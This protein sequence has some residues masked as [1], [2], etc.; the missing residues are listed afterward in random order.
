VP[1]GGRAFDALA[2]LAA[3][4]GATVGKETLLDA[5]WPGLTVEENNLQVQIS[6]LRKVLGEGWIVTVPGRGYR[7][8]PPPSHVESTTA[9]TLALPDKPSIA[10]LPFQNI[11]GDPEQEYFADGMVEEIIT[12]LSRVRWFFVIARNSSFAYKGKSPDVRQVGRELGVRYVL[13]GSVRKAGNRVRITGQLVDAITGAHVWADRFDG[14]LE[15]IFDLQDRVTSS[16]VSAIEPKIRD[17]EIVRAQRKPTES[18]QAYDLV[19]RAIPH[20]A[21]RSRDGHREATR[22]LEHAIKIDPNYALALSF[23][24]WCHNLPWAQGWLETRPSHHEIMRLTH[25]ALRYGADDPAVLANAG[26]LISQAGGDLDGGLALME[27]SLA[28]NPNS[29]SASATAGGMYAY[30]GNIDKALAYA[31]RATRLDPVEKFSFGPNF[32][33]AVAHFVAGRYETTLEF[34]GKNL[35]SNPTNTSALRFHAACLGLL[36]RIDE[37]QHAVQRML[38]IAP[39]WT[40]RRVR[41]RYEIDLNHIFK[42]PN[43]LDALCE[44]L[45]LAGLPE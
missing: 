27:R 41:E 25:I 31:E 37:G 43:V 29:A 16:V 30:A 44:G 3:A 23:L 26:Y 34:T 15:D 6:A 20:M 1:V 28:L 18:L 8:A 21:A 35:R 13:G 4:A 5:V 32:A 36:G 24:A 42:T 2:V 40:L 17:A 9:P 38:E 33:F 14:A 19:L 10:V 22:L 11:S 7:L 39:D 45:R 12:G